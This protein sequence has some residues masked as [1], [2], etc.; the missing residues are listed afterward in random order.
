MAT[1][2]WKGMGGM[3]NREIVLQLRL[4]RRLV[5]VAAVI[6]AFGAVAVGTVFAQDTTTINGCVS[7]KTGH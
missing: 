7:K 1:L 2:R 5:A 4:S 3:G 6:F